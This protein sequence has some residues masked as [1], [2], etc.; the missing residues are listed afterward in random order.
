MIEIRKTFN[1]PGTR[2]TKSLSVSF[3]ILAAL[4]LLAP[5]VAASNVLW[6]ATTALAQT[7]NP[8]DILMHILDTCTPYPQH[9][10]T[11]YNTTGELPTILQTTG[12]LITCGQALGIVKHICDEMRNAA[13]GSPAACGDQRYQNWLTN[14][15]PNYPADEWFGNNIP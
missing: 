13:A 9:T 3:M 10:R 14:D 1:K 7:T 11:P 5:N 6:P 4:I 2:V 12:A 8:T 15:F